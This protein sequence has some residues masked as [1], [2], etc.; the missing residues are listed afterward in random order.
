MDNE[1]DIPDGYR[2]E[3]ITESILGF[4]TGYG[5]LSITKVTTKDE[6]KTVFL[7]ATFRPF[8]LL[9]SI[10]KFLGFTPVQEIQISEDDLEKLRS[11]FLFHDSMDET[12]KNLSYIYTKAEQKFGRN[13]T[14]HKAVGQAMFHQSRRGSTDDDEEGRVEVQ[15]SDTKGETSDT[16]VW[17]G[18]HTISVNGDT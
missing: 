3:D 14:I 8:G 5:D 10:K 1:A 13:S 7:A 16:V 12:D 11:D 15:I 18:E 2:P 6:K 9:S 4:R 17:N